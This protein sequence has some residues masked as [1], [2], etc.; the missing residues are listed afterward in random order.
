[1]MLFA[2]AGLS[3]ADRGGFLGLGFLLLPGLVVLFDEA[4]KAHPD[5]MNML[6]LRFFYFF[7]LRFLGAVSIGVIKHGAFPQILAQL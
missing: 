4:E 7:F 2:M 3:A 6:L 5:V 1:M